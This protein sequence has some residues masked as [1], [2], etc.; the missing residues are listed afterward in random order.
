MTI[1]I[2]LISLLAISIIAF[3]SLL[4]LRLPGPEYFNMTCRA[5]MDYRGV[6]QNGGFDFKGDVS[7]FFNDDKSGRYYISGSMSDNEGDYYIS[8]LVNFN[9]QHR[10]KANYVFTPVAVEKSV[11]DNVSEKIY[12]RLKR[13]LPLAQKVTIN[14]G[15]NENYVLFSN[16]VS[17]LFICVSL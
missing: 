14:M 8:R 2:G 11:H 7:F 3:S 6:T 5:Y 17:P 1:R 12:D 10:E 16:A 13:I 4:L 9:Y 15:L